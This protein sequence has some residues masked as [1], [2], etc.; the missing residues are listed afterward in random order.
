MRVS[1]FY[2][3]L[4]FV[5]LS[6][7]AGCI[8]FSGC[9]SSTLEN[10]STH[11]FSYLSEDRYSSDPNFSPSLDETN[12]NDVTNSSSS[13]WRF[14]GTGSEEDIAQSMIC[15]AFSC[16]ISEYTILVEND[17]GKHSVTFTGEGPDRYL[18]EYYD[19]LEYPATV[20]HFSKYN[21]ADF[22]L[23]NESSEY[24]NPDMIDVAKNFVYKLYGVNCEGADISAFGYKNKISIQLQIDEQQI[25]HV[26]FYYKEPYAPV[27]IMFID[28]AN[29]SK[30]LMDANNARQYM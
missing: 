25:F 3:I 17:D 21:D 18:F 16:D 14:D 24:F 10:V 1:W 11:E 27:G 6:A 4:T 15:K 2:K 12:S 8:L 26:R 13:F 20:Y 19:D 29:I 9:A 23:A 7:V 28:N 30:Y 5:A 22:D